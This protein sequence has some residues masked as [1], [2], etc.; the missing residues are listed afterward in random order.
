MD[1]C[2]SQRMVGA[3]PY[4]VLGVANERRT[5]HRMGTYW[6]Y[7]FME[8]RSCHFASQNSRDCQQSRGD[9]EAR[10]HRPLDCGLRRTYAVK[11]GKGPALIGNANSTEVV[12]ISADS[13]G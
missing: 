5:G 2:P 12:L 13:G 9:N 11:D 1:K 4:L 8:P 10:R 7:S 6:R 3:S